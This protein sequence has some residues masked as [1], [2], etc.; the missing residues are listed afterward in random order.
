MKARGIINNGIRNIQ[1]L[2]YLRALNI[3]TLLSW[4]KE[5]LN[6]EKESW[7]MVLS[8]NEECETKPCQ[9]KI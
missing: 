7:P 6:P 4:E 9:K 1:F 3:Y 2:N 5:T 8:A